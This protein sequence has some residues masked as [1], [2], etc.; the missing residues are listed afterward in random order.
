[1]IDSVSAGL[2]F[3]MTA[4]IAQTHA[5]SAGEAEHDGDSDDRAAAASSGGPVPEGLLPDYLGRAVNI[6]A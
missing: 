3:N 2:P 4:Q 5:E 1:M 6:L